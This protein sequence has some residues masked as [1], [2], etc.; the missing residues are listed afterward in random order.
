METQH[1]IPSHDTFRRVFSLTHEDAFEQCFAAWTASRADAFEDEIVAIDGKTMRRSFDRS[2]GQSPLHIVSA[3]ASDQSLVLAQEVTQEKSNEITAIPAV[4]ETLQLEDALVTIDAMG[5]QTKI[6]EAILE[7]KADYLLALKANHKTGYN[8]VKEHFD[9]QRSRRGS[10][11]H[12][13]E[14]EAKH[15]AFDESHGRLV[16]R[17]VFAST[18]AAELPALSKSFKVA[19]ASAGGRSRD[20]SI[21]EWGLAIRSKHPLL[22]VQPRRRR[23]C[24]TGDLMLED[25]D[26]RGCGSLPLVH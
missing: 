16:R 23:P 8:A 5:C 10:L 7:K 22:F 1:G 15:D 13:P 6:A 26:V 11:D 3:W 12:E 4:L 14:T 19:G 20:D 25:A 17:R 9:D 2:T 18:D 21:G 24:V